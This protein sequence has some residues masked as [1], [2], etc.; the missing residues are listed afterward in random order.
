VR[1]TTCAT[2]ATTSGKRGR[3][4]RICTT[5]TLAATLK[6]QTGAARASLSR[7]GVLYA[8][9]TATG[10]RVTLQLRRRLSAGRYTLALTYKRNG[11]TITKRTPITITEQ[12]R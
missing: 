9:G 11:R 4:R 5:R 6:P 7:A 3:A 12:A 1:L 8:T 10:T 2:A